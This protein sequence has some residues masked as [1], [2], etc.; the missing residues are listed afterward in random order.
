[1]RIRSNNISRISKNYNSKGIFS[2]PNSSARHPVDDV[3]HEVKDKFKDLKETAEGDAEPKR[4]ATTQG[5][6]QTSILWF[7]DFKYYLIP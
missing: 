3:S 7:I 5:V 6:E 1:M 2:P 4:E